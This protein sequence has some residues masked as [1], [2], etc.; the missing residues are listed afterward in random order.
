MLENTGRVGVAHCLVFSFVAFEVSCDSPGSAVSEAQQK[1]VLFEESD[2][3][4][5][6]IV[7]PY[8]PTLYSSGQRNLKKP[9]SMIE[10]ARRR[11]RVGLSRSRFSMSTPS[12]RAT[13]PDSFVAGV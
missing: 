9:P 10:R 4:A 12:S 5:I 3:S 13:G 2:L 11:L 1:Q 6:T 7:A 8:I